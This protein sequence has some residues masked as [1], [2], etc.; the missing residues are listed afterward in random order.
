MCQQIHIFI[1]NISNNG[2]NAQHNYYNKCIN[3]DA[4][5]GKSN[6]EEQPHQRQTNTI[7]EVNKHTL[8]RITK[9]YTE[10]NKHNQSKIVT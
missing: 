3:F 10:V 6:V 1:C 8:H 4:Q 7:I 2:S 5:C 9:T